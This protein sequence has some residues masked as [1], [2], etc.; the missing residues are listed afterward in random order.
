MGNEDNRTRASDA[1][2]KKERKGR[3]ESEGNGKDKN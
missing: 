2:E 3:K 1:R